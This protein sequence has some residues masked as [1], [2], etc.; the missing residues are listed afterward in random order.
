VIDEPVQPK[1]A[2]RVRRL[3]WAAVLGA[4]S[5]LLTAVAAWAFYEYFPSRIGPQQPISFSH[6]F[7]VTEKKLSCIFCH[8]GAVDSDRAG[9]PPVETC[10]LC[11]SQ[12]IVTHPQIQKLRGY[13]FASGDYRHFKPLPSD[14]IA[15]PAERLEWVRVNQLPDYVYFS[16]ERHVRKGFDCGRCHGDVAGMDRVA[17]VNDFTMGF[18]VKCHRDEK[19]SH[20]CYTCHR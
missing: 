11:H 20:D 3:T 9:V 6:R 17:L 5:L 2:K 4:I 14:R 10:M 16:H 1:P 19:F 18:C 12:I 8:G 13:Y 7:H 15:K